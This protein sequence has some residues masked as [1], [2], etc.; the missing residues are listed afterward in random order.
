MMQFSGC[1][2]GH[3]GFQE[4]NLDFASEVSIMTLLDNPVR[5]IRENYEG[6]AR[7]KPC[8][9]IVSASLL[10]AHSKSTLYC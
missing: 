4:L 8:T 5:F 9:K 7:S 3:H 2:I 6:G 10:K 1:R